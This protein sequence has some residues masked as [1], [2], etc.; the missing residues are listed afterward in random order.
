ME[1]APKPCPNCDGP[2]LGRYCHSCGQDNRRDQ[3]KIRDWWGDL[4][5]GL[6]GMNSVLVRTLVHLFRRP[7]T[8]ARLYVQGQR[9]RYLSPIRFALLSCAT[10]WIAV[11][12]AKARI[13][14]IAQQVEK[15]EP[16]QQLLTDHGELV[17]LGLLP[18]M[19]IPFHL[20]YWDSKTTFAE[21]LSFTLF[22]GG[23]IFS[24][25]TAMALL[26]AFQPDLATPISIADQ[27][28]MLGY[29]IA[30]LR[31]FYAGRVAGQWLRIPLA[32]G[33]V[34]LVSSLGIIALLAIFL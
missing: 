21:T 3:L 19:A 23:L 24:W 8:T 10:W 4:L 11:A 34:I 14:D 9:Q 27:A 33:G 26:G 5:D 17:N 7:G 32:I 31:G 6:S 28:L 1:D 25:R 2:Q 20:V 12:F 15:M 13:E 18:L 22:L 16:W 30:S 29:L